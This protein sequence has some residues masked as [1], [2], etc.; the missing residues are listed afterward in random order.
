M[1]YLKSVFRLKIYLHLGREEFLTEAAG[2]WNQRKI[3]L[4][5]K[6][7]VYRLQKVHLYMYIHS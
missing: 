6:L 3:G 7:L 5:P 2:F 4:L 1:I